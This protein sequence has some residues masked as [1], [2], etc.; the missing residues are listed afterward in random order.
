M[1]L[2]LKGKRALITGS[3][4][5]IGEEIARTLAAEGVIVTIHGRNAERVKRITQSIHDAGGKAVPLIADLEPSGAGW[6][7][8]QEARD[9]LGGVDI[10]VNNAPGFAMPGWFTPPPEEWQRAYRINVV[11]AV[12]LIHALVPA[13]REAR[14]GRIIQISSNVSTRPLADLAAYG[15]SKAAMNHL[16]ASLALELADTG[17]TVN[18]VSPGLIQTESMQSNLF[19]MGVHRGWGTTWEQ[20][21]THLVKEYFPTPQGRIGEPRDVARAVA[22]LASPLASYIHGAMLRVDGG[23]ALAVP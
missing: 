8:A 2:E 3:S 19:A 15:A 18:T 14:F 4:M 13:M 5:G 20:V 7:V 23:S 6:R 17:V 22:F 11:A 1:D 10:L 21:K 16:T 9:K 12:E